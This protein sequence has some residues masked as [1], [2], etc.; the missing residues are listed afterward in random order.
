MI[1]DFGE[2]IRQAASELRSRIE[3]KM[4]LFS[5]RMAIVRVEIAL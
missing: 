3:K 2:R 1:W 4:A 5:L